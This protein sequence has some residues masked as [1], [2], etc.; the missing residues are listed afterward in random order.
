MMDMAKEST[1]WPV[2]TLIAVLLLGA[3][4]VVSIF[5]SQSSSG[6]QQQAPAGGTHVITVTAIGYATGQPSEELI[7]ISANATGNTTAN[8]VANLSRTTA[9]LNT[10]IYPF[11]N[12][13]LSNIQTTAY[14]VQAICNGTVYEINQYQISQPAV[15]PYSQNCNSTVVY[16]AEEQFSVTLNATRADPAVSAVSGISNV[17]VDYVESQ[18]SNSQIASLKPIA[19]AAAMSNATSQAMATLGQG[20][21]ISALNIT[22]DN[23]GPVFPLV[24]SAAS[25]SS[26]AP[27]PIIYQG[28]SSV[29]GTVTVVFSY[30]KK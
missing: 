11:L 15:F 4:A 12:G 22:V 7:S 10:T 27:Q 16:S 23:Y 21:N 2:I 29:T 3:V 5:H 14:S 6:S 26:A 28:S 25:G 9:L 1:L 18:F 8:A 30:Q 17:Y 19:L 24:A 13:N 20:Y